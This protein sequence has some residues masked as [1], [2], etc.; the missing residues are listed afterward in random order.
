M[1]DHRFS[2][3]MGTA[4]IGTINP[5]RYRSYYYDVETG[6]YYLQTRYY[7]PEVGRF[8]NSDA[9]EY[10]G[11]GPELLNYNLFAYC[12]NNPIEGYDPEGTWNWGGVIA[13]L[14]IVAATVITVATFGIASPIGAVVATAAIST[15]VTIAYAAATDQT[16][17]LDLSFS[18]TD[19]T[20]YRSIGGSLVIDFDNG[21]IEFYGHSGCC[22]SN[23]SNIWFWAV[24]QCWI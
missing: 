1:T 3:T 10:L 4:N 12:G 22:Q 9:Y 11:E 15:G 2:I 7:D 14:G 17:V 18:V 24:I 5:F 13:G 8:I 21:W 6:L 20:E 23:I 16:A 19:G